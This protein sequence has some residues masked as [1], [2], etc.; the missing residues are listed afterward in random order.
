MH[1]GAVPDDV[2]GAIRCLQY[3]VHSSLS[4]V[5]GSIYH[6][7][8]YAKKTDDEWAEMRAEILKEHID[9]MSKVGESTKQLLDA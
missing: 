1:I 3:F 6:S 7:S 5:N 9:T 8:T 4:G 2:D